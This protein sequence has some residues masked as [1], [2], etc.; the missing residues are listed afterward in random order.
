VY[1]VLQEINL[2]EIN[3]QNPR[4]LQFILKALIF[5][6]LYPR[7]FRTLYCVSDSN[8]FPVTTRIKF[9]LTPNLIYDLKFKIYFPVIVR[10]RDHGST[11]VKVLC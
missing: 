7:N 6:V 8:S 11:V 3:I 2:I 5:Q 1:W 9:G 4:V 10:K